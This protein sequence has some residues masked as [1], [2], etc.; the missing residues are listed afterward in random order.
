MGEIFQ[1]NDV[2]FEELIHEGQT[3][4][5]DFWAPNCAPCKLME[6]GL[7]RLADRHPADLRILK[8]NVNECPKVSSRYYVR[9]LPTLLFLKDGQVKNQ[10]V[11]AVNP[12]QIEKALSEVMP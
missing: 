11:G 7:E 4:I 9:S 8:V 12:T 10:L 5:V 2:N 6:P 3:I 1:A